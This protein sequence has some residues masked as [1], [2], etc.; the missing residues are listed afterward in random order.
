MAERSFDLV[1]ADVRIVRLHGQDRV[2]IWHG[3]QLVFRLPLAKACR[4]Y[5]TLGEVLAQPHDLSRSEP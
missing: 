4:L 5:T 3:K 1:E 2:E